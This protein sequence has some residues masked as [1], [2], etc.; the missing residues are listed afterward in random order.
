MLHFTAYAV[1]QICWSIIWVVLFGTLFTFVLKIAPFLTSLYDLILSINPTV[2]YTDSWQLTYC[3]Y[4]PVKSV[5]KSYLSRM[6]TDILSLPYS[7]DRPP[8]IWMLSLDV[9]V[10]MFV[11]Y[12]RETALHSRNWKHKIL[13]VSG[14]SLFRC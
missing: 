1:L 14:K 4:C 10:C 2:P 6:L 7:H 9:F 5:C 8:H 12:C 13:Q 11:L 3:T